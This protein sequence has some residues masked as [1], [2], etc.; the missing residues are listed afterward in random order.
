MKAGADDDVEDGGAATDAVADT[1]GPG[2]DAEAA[3]APAAADDSFMLCL[4]RADS[5]KSNGCDPGG[6]RCA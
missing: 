2:L 1:E 4:R 3:A 6:A 5:E